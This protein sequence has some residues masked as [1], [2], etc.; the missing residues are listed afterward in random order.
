MLYFSPFIKRLL[1]NLGVVLDE[2]EPEN[3]LEHNNED[4]LTGEEEDNN[5]G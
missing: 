3:E 5:N 2:P 4:T 1:N